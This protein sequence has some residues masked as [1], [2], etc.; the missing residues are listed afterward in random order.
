M[1]V[2]AFHLAHPGNAMKV[3]AFDR[4]KPGVTMDTIHPLLA[5]EV[6]HAW[7][8]WKRGVVR[9]NYSRVDEPGVVLVFE[10]QD[11]DDAMQLLAEFP[12][13]KAGYLEW[14]CIP[15]TV[16]F[17]LEALFNDVAIERVKMPDSEL[18]WSKGQKRV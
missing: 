17:P 10:A 2:T 8:L 4:F 7:R 15:V 5:E 6:A 1:E 9:E 18:E 12:L 11:A 13:S 16:P 3:I 14:T